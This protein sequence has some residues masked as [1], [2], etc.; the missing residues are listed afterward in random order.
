MGHQRREFQGNCNWLSVDGSWNVNVKLN[1]SGKLLKLFIIVTLLLQPLE[2]KDMLQIGMKSDVWSLGCILY[3]LVYGHTPFQH[4]TNFIA[5]M[6]A[7][8]NPNH[9]IEFANITDPNLL[10]VLKVGSAAN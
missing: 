9:A 8:I 1:M 3:S 10:N 6:Q 5:K 4:I 2:C 7:I